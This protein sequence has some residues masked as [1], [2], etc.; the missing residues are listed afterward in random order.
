[1][2]LRGRSFLKEADFTRDDLAG[3]V[4]LASELKASKRAGT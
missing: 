4:D 3:L 1:M 2:D